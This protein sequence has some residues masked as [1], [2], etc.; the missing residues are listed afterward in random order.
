[1]QRIEH[2]FSD[3]ILKAFDVDS[4]SAR[5]CSFAFSTKQPPGSWKA[6]TFGLPIPFY[7]VYTSGATYGEVKSLASGIKAE[8]Y[9]LLAEF[10]TH[11]LL[12]MRRAKKEENQPLL[13]GVKK[14]EDLERIANTIR[15]FNFKSDELT[16][17]SSLNSA[18]DLLRVG[19]ERYYVNRGL[20]ANHYLK[21]RLF[22]SLSERGRE[23]KG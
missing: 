6:F 20:F 11:S 8:N 5:P 16:A 7:L 21:E 19:A 4:R 2:S 23:E 15:K 14:E 10:G 17:H 9:V 13:V 22:R 12:V 1:M 3:R 18:V